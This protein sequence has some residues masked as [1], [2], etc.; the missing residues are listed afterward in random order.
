MSAAIPPPDRHSAIR[1]DSWVTAAAS[2]E[3][4]LLGGEK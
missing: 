1:A 4:Q 2:E 3:T